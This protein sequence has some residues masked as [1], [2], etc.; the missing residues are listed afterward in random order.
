MFKEVSKAL[1]WAYMMQT[2]VIIDKPSMAGMYGFI[3]ASKNELLI[4]LSAQEAV[5]Q[6]ADI[7]FI[8]SSL[9][10]KSCA[11]YLEAKYGRNFT[12]INELVDRIIARLG[13]GVTYRRG[14]QYIVAK[15]CG[16][17]VSKEQIR[18]GLK[19]D[20][21]RVAEIRDKAY[22]VLDGIHKVAIGSVENELIKRR[23]V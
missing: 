5:Q 2:K 9:N 4:G 1:S 22:S 10:D 20:N 21:N 15:Y 18:N 12:S 7:I 23:L 14:V 11:Q 3:P 6:S 8:V 13:T 17:R 16:A 19:C